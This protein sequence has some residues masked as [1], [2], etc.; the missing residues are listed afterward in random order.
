MSYMTISTISR[1]AL[2]FFLW[3]TMAV[4]PKVSTMETVVAAS[5]IR[6]SLSA[7]FFFFPSFICLQIR[8][9]VIG[10]KLRFL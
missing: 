1:F 8:R 6:K 9:F 4:V 7:G 5:V 2:L 10:S 3:S